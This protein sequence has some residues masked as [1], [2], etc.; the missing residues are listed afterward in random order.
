MTFTDNAVDADTQSDDETFEER[1]KAI[2]Q[3]AL[4]CLARREYAKAELVSKLQQKSYKLSEIN[5]VLTDLEQ[6]GYLSD[7][8]YADLVVRSRINGGYGPFKIKVEL[9]QKGVSET[10][11]DSVFNEY[12]VN[13]FDLARMTLEKRFGHAE[14]SSISP[15]EFAKRARYLTN[16]GFNQ[17]HISA[18]LPSPAF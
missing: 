16:R 7:E 3:F 14:D 9:K 13:W 4:R 12:S 17:E 18:S 15:N 6:R 8:R 10:I 2:K 5:P 11:I 1:T